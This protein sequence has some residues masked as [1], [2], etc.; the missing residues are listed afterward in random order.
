VAQKPDL[1]VGDEWIFHEVGT[2]DSQ[3][4]DRRWL[5]RIVESL[6]DDKFRVQGYVGSEVVDSSWNP[7]NLERPDFWPLDFKFPLTVGDSWTFA[8][9]AGAFDTV[10]RIF[11]Q[12]GEHKVIAL[13]SITVPAGTFSCFKIVGE[14]SW[15]GSYDATLADYMHVE[16]WNMT[17]WYCP[18]IRYMAKLH[19]ER[20]LGGTLEK[21]R[22]DFLDSELTWFDRAIPA[23]NVV[24]RSEE[25]D[26][27]RFD[28]SWDVSLA[29]EA[30]EDIPATSKK[31]RVAVTGGEFVIK[32]GE[33]GVPGYS[34][35]TGYPAENGN[36]TLDG[37]GISAASKYFGQTYRARFVGRQDGHRFALVGHY[38]VLPCT[39]TMS[40]AQASAAPK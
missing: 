23:P 34:R 18:E 12:R 40:P 11:D 26:A 5:R 22:Y 1:R 17:R 30:V 15:V 25:P 6:P 33:L 16:R 28:G 20:Y 3:P 24:A 2:V 35:I 10:G 32:S 37:Q 19:L 38:G 21:G 36:L 7:R 13:E 31:F 8:A 9:P 39:L 29:C 4:I 27:R 14:S